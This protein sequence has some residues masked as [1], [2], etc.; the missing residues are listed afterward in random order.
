MEKYLPENKVTVISQTWC[1][2]SKITKHFLKSIN[3]DFKVY[4]AD[5]KEIPDQVLKEVTKFI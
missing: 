5:K 1:N 2:H 4:E 3:V